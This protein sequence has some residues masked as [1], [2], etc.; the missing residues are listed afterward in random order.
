MEVSYVPS[1]Q[2]LN[3]GISLHFEEIFKNYITCKTEITAICMF[4]KPTWIFHYK[5]CLGLGQ[6]RLEACFSSEYVF[7]RKEP[8][9]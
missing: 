2:E 8:T 5:L 9:C 4:S 3:L 1:R 7:V 6:K